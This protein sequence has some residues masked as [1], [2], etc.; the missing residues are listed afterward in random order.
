MEALIFIGRYFNFTNYRNC[1][2]IPSLKAHFNTL[3]TKIIDM[4]LL[5]KSWVSCSLR[6]P[7]GV[8]LATFSFVGSSCLDLSPR[9]NLLPIWYALKE[10]WQD[11]N[12]YLEFGSLGR[13]LDIKHVSSQY[14]VL[15][16]IC[17]WWVYWWQYD[18]FL[19]CMWHA[20]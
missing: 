3:H 9:G 1:R 15:L 5:R 20:I 13:G 12:K 18:S 14:H 8:T 16:Y 11:H 7:L 6:L 17:L 19:Q 10:G 4:A 2:Y